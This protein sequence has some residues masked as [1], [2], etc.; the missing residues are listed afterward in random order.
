M[1]TPESRT[2]RHRLNRF[3]HEGGKWY[4]DA[5]E[6]RQGPFIRREE[7]VAYLERHKRKYGWKRTGD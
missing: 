4:L 2:R 6:G 5:R 7:A 1:S 3:F